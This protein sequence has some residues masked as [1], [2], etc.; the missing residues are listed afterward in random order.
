MPDDQVGALNRQGGGDFAAAGMDGGRAAADPEQQGVDVEYDGQAELEGGH[1][2]TVHQDADGGPLVYGDLVPDMLTSSVCQA[3]PASA[4]R[5][6]RCPG[7]YA[8]RATS[9]PIRSTSSRAAMVDAASCAAA[10]LVVS[11]RCAKARP[12]FWSPPGDKISPAR[13]WAASASRAE[14]QIQ[15]GGRTALSSGRHGRPS[16]IV[17]VATPGWGSRRTVWVG[18]RPVSRTLTMSGRAV[19]GTARTSDATAICWPERGRSRAELSDPVGASA[20]CGAR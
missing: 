12:R 3:R 17:V 9:T 6:R 20:V 1:L 10:F 2:P 7:A 4:G 8:T 18:S 5:R 16:L 14:Q 13:I 11:G 15:G 19:S